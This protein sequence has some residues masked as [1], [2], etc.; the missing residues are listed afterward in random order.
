MREQIK[1]TNSEFDEIRQEMDSRIAKSTITSAEDVAKQRVQ[2]QQEQASDPFGGAELTEINGQM[3][4]VHRVKSDDSL[5]RLCL[6]YN[7]DERVIMNAN[8][9]FNDMI[10][11]KQKLYI[12]FT[13]QI[14]FTPAKELTV[15]RAK[16]EEEQRRATCLNLMQDYIREV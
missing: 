6:M 10:H 3:F 11:H 5:P 13:D 14:K 16:Y 2:N 15:D 8:D 4:I 12:P 9:L 7:L 1:K